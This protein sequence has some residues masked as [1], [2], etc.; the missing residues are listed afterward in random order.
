LNSLRA[1]DFAAL[2]PRWKEALQVREHLDP[3]GKL[4]NQYLRKVVL[5]A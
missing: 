4:L 1:T 2:Y 3:Q 5:D